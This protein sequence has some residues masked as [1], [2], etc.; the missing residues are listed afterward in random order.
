MY[1]IKNIALLFS[2]C[3]LFISCSTNYYL[4]QTANE[5][6][7]STD[8]IWDEIT[9]P[10]NKHILV[11]GNDGFVRPIKYGNIDGRVWCDYFDNLIKI[12]KIKSSELKYL[13]F[14][15]SDSTY[16]FKG[17][18]YKIENTYPSD[19]NISVSGSHGGSVSVKGYYRKDGTYVKSH[20][21]KA[22]GRSGGGR[23]R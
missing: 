2:L 4:Y 23:R 1:N 8:N 21:R 7:I 22:P 10:K 14:D 20:T 11:K 16:V 13:T 15:S 9:I 19:T 5:V 17:K 6:P 3:L 12:Q 18:K